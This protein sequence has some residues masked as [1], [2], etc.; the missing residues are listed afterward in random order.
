MKTIIRTILL[1]SVSTLFFNDVK[2]QGNTLDGANIGFMAATPPNFD[3]WTARTGTYRPAS[4][5]GNISASN[6]LNYTVFNFTTSHN[7]PATAKFTDY[8]GSSDDV[9]KIFY[10][11]K[12]ETDEHS[13]GGLKKIP[14]HLGFDRSVRLGPTSGETGGNKSAELSY[15]LKVTE[16]NALLTFCYAI[17][18]MAPHYQFHFGNPTFEVDVV[19]ADDEL[20]SECC[21]FQNCG[22]LNCSYLPT[23]W[24]LGVGS[25]SPGALNN[26]VW[27]YSDWNQITI[28]LLE[29]LNKTVKVRIRISGCIYDAHGGYGYFAAKVGEPSIS[30]SGCVGEGDTVTTA[31]API[32]FSKY[33]WFEIPNGLTD[34]YDIDGVYSADKVVSTDRVLAITNQLM[35]DKYTKSFAV[36]LTSPTQHVTWISDPAPACVTYIPVEVNDMRP[37][38]DAMIEHQYIPT[39]PESDNDEIGFLFEDVQPRSASYPLD[40]QRLEFGD[41]EVLELK[42]QPDKTWKADES[43]TPLADNHVRLTYNA[44]NGQIDTIFHTYEAGEYVFVRYAHAHPANPDDSLECLKQEVLNVKVPVRP[45]LVLTSI[46]TVCMGDKVTITASSPGDDATDY[47]YQWWYGDDDVQTTNPFFEGKTLTINSLEED[48]T[49]HVRV[50]TPEGFYRW[51]WDSVKVQSFPDIHIEGDTMICIG[52]KVHLTATDLSGGTLGLRWS[53]QKPNSS[54]SVGSTDNPAVF[55]DAVKQD[56]SIFILAETTNHCFSWQEKRIIVVKPVVVS[57]KKEICIDDEVILTG[58][59]AVDYSWRATPE[60]PSLQEGVKGLNPVRV[61]PKQTTEYTMTG[62]GQNGCEANTNITI[63]VVP[64]PVVKL[65]FSPDFVDMDE[66]II[67]FTDSSDYSSK[68]V[69]TFSD[70]G[71]AEGGNITYEFSDINAD[72]VAVHLISSNYLGC[73][74]EADTTIPV[75]L[76]AVWMPNAFSPDGDDINDYFFFLT[77]NNLEDVSFEIFD[78]WGTKMYSYETKLY[79]Y[80]SDDDVKTYGWN[81]RYKNKYVQNGTYVWRLSYRRVGNTRVY[82][83]HGTVTLIR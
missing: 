30:L 58:S 25:C 40:W 34:Q 66:P 23:G 39:N 46:D 42:R 2:S 57:N 81:G 35:D 11:D 32:G 7:N 82:D 22:D 16:Q 37:N 68:S 67:M 63:T 12:N 74:S 8:W 31:E 71:K 48:I 80:K 13:L 36:R 76:F 47:T 65:G 73:S 55:E 9:F 24:N 26:N 1:I 59:G 61:S 20:V 78:R 52:E 70:G 77:K 75:A 18:L 14:T 79:T 44:Q 6:P 49:V 56:T 69:W 4:G 29:Y 64:D 19:D 45:K 3:G 53:Y 62:Y 5:T 21:F 72:S 17:V 33:E 41:G 50:I 27:L 15:R 54:T 43:V 28:N 10:T 60:D 51:A 83:E 38:F